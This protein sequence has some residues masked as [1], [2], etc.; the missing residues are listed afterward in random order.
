M[1]RDAL[2][3]EI[4]NA[5]VSFTSRDSN[6]ATIDEAGIAR[7]LQEGITTITATSGNVSATSQLNVLLRTLVINEVLA[8]PPDGV[9]GDANHDGTRSG[10]EDEFIEL[11]NATT[12]ALDISRWTIRTRAPSGLTE[13]IRHT[14][15]AGTTLPPEDALVIFGGGNFDA[16]H[17]AFGGA[18]VTKASTAGLSLTNSGLTIVVRDREI[19]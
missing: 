14:F 11:V 5:P 4:I 10:T 12:S 3:D 15:A 19:S 13:T 1:A 17:P 7:G 6:I 16:N 8:D 9:A 2:G 18:S